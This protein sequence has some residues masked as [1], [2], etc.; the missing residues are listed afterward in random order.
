MAGGWF[1]QDSLFV[2][3]VRELED[4]GLEPRIR[5][6][7][8]SPDGLRLRVLK[9]LTLYEVEVVT[10]WRDETNIGVYAQKEF[11]E[12]SYYCAKLFSTKYGRNILERR[13][14]FATGG[15]R[16]ELEDEEDF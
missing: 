9:E 13:H 16:D 10:G 15:E 7:R 3:A 12:G 4:K 2:K 1:E 5:L 14:Y 6:Y 8:V 11:G